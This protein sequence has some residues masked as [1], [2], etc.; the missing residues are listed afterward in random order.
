MTTTTTTMDS[1]HSAR[2]EEPPSLFQPIRFQLAA[3]IAVQAVAA[4]V[5]VVPLIAL[6]ELGRILL[7][8]SP[9]PGRAWAVV[10]MAGAAVILRL[11]FAVLA[12]TI[13]HYA[14]N[15]LQLGIRRGLVDRLGRIPLGWF[16]SRSSGVVK[17]AVGDDVDA[18]HHLVAHSALELTSAI[19][20]PLISLVYLFWVDWRLASITLVPLSIGI[21]LFRRV[22]TLFQR[23]FAAMFPIMREIN[24]TAV[25]FVTGVAVVKT[26]GQSQQSYRRFANTANRFST[27]WN[28]SIGGLAMPR[29]LAE[30]TL[31]P[32][33]MLLVTLIFGSVFV[34]AGTMSG[35]DVLAFAVLGT[36][37]S[38]PILAL[39]YAEQDLRAGRAAATRVNALMTTPVVEVN[40]PTQTPTARTVEIDRVDFAYEHDHPVLTGITLTL[41]PGT[42]TALVGP[43]GAGKSTLARLVPRFFDPT[44]G[45]IKVGSADVTA[46][47]NGELYRHIGF[48][49]QEVRLLRDTIRENI[50]LARPE[51]DDE[52][53]AAAARGAQIH[54]RILALPRGYDSVVGQDALLSGGEAQRV[55]IARAILADRPIIVLDEAA[56]FADPESENEIQRALSELTHGKTVLVIAHRL[57][58]IANADHIAVLDGGRI[59]EQGSHDE[60][61]ARGGLYRRLWTAQ[62][63]Q[64]TEPSHTATSA[65]GKESR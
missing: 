33:V 1:N 28:R 6:V 57:R 18:L 9:D 34:T 64:A 46:I 58:S 54:E 62:A 3:A 39:S 11:L 32:G 42:V 65:T 48:V 15:D 30:L 8:T 10:G 24:Q 52:Q 45:T 14:E 49:F 7:A 59:V 20:A 29:S 13:S 23:G 40:E 12:N 36:G 35:A 25:E 53:V 60:L 4:A 26:F 55:A 44:S 51:A 41:R 16:D 37:V 22:G 43:S 38:A 61:L 2:S 21:I 50:R 47:S 56:S 19:V 5:S 63:G 27:G 17:Q 31:S